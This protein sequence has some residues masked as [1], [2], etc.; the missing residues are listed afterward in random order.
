MEDGMDVMQ[1]TND[2]S[3]VKV[4]DERSVGEGLAP[5]ET[6]VKMIL[7]CGANQFFRRDD[8]WSSAECRAF[9]LSKARERKSMLLPSGWSMTIPTEAYIP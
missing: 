9:L 6:F 3:D 5:P 1:F 4:E 8:H 7:I 2:N